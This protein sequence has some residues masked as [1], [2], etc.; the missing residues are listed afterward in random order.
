MTSTEQRLQKKINALLSQYPA[1]PC[2]LDDK[3]K[4]SASEVSFVS[5]FVSVRGLHPTLRLRQYVEMRV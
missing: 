4:T 1:L 5:V 3:N 2:A